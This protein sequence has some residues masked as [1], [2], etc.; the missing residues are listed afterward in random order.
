MK[1]DA[2]RRS[3]P[4]L[5]PAIW[6][7]YR[8]AK[9]AVRL[10][11]VEATDEREAIAQGRNRAMVADHQGRQHPVRPEAGRPHKPHYVKCCDARSMSE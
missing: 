10:G 1:I 7:I 9:K 4:P 11:E 8:A 6:T 3:Q 5:Q 2:V